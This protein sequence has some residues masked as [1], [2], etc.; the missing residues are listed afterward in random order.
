MQYKTLE[1]Q[2]K[3]KNW[4]EVEREWLAI[5]EQPGADT[6]RLL[7]VIDM[8]VKAGQGSLAST[9]G[10][11]WL[12]TVK[13]L[14]PAT[15][16]LQLGRGLLLRLPDGEELREEILS[17]YRETHKDKPT[18]EAW[19]ERSGLKS[20]KSVRRA[21]R[22]LETG[23][24]L[25]TGV[26]L[27]HRTENEPAEI[28]EFDVGADTAVVK[29][30]RR[31]R[32]FDITQLIEDYDIAR[33]NDFR[34]LSHFQQDRLAT[35]L[36]Q[37]PVKL[38]VGILRSRGDRIDRDE[39]KLMLV[40]RYLAAEKW[41][42]WW[43]RLRDGIKR[44][45]NLRLEGR[46]PM[47]LIFDEVG[48]SLEG[49]TWT[50]FSQ[51]Q[52]PRE[53][54]EALEGYLRETKRQKTAPD[55]AFLGRVQA[56]LVE[57]VERFTRHQEPAQAFATALVLGRLASEGLPVSTD[58]HGLAVRMLVE[59]T[60]P[61][62]VV[63]SLPDT[64]LWPL[65]LKCVEQALPEKWPEVLAELVLCAPGAQC[66]VIARRIEA[67]GRGDLLASV[68]ARATADPG[69]YT[70]AMM[71]I[72]KGPNIKTELPIP[73]PMEMLNIILAL[74]GPA[75]T[76]VG[77]NVGQSTVEMRAKVRSGLAVKNYE[78]F[79]Q[80]LQGLDLAMAQTV[81]RQIER[82]DGL[83]PRV[84]EDMGTI[85]YEEYPQLYLKPKVQMW[86]DE[87]TLYFT[88]AGYDAKQAEIDHLVNVKMHENA[89]AIGEAAAHGDLSENAEYKF[90]LE[91][92]D[93]LR[94]RL[95][96]LNQEISLA[97]VLEPND[98]PE[99]HVSIGQR[100]TLTPTAG[101]EAVVMT[102]LGPNDG[103]IAKRVYSYLTPVAKQILGKRI[104][105]V[106][107]LS[108]EGRDGEYR[109]ERIERAI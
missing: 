77:K 76:S 63:A 5:I 31:T 4:S 106:A 80:C 83:G 32:T 88:Q 10:W 99:D 47:F 68:V 103:D 46:S 50:S 2:V 16:A 28:V 52:T 97:R 101:G 71:W 93:L 54:L 108:L 60:D 70:E 20:G 94:A 48:Q 6:A 104:G 35:L 1:S 87:G 14:R 85:M 92:R 78:R 40:P 57:H 33:E 89:K 100:I 84:Q 18:L 43:A 17:L 27:T 51:G 98:V 7:G 45:R 21:L 23:L 29:T 58:V 66:D 82:A 102:I 39:L 15:E 72:W 107:T 69:Q 64:R 25:G 56:A 61:V 73:P 65:A 55:T 3:A 12:S 62:S 75:R 34:V 95:A 105:D 41:P 26:Y 79:R 19:I 44:S 30:P 67:V 36:E 81:R 22:F 24:R 38:A 49:E 74:V 9:L 37:D 13:E 53:W 8:M 96:K 42:D 86:E 59:A 11:A 91:E 109:V 90:A